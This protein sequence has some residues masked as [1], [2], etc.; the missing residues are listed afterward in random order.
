MPNLYTSRRLANSP[1]IRFALAKPIFQA[2]KMGKRLCR[3]QKRHAP[4]SHIPVLLAGEL[5]C[6]TGEYRLPIPLG[7][8]RYSAALDEVTW[9]STNYIQ[10]DPRTTHSTLLV[11]VIDQVKCLIYG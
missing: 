10:S 11:F 9:A 2:S 3:P 7:V 1:R 6:L 8:R 4:C 5:G